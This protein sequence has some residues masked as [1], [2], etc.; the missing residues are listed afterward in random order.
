[1]V[2][3]CIVTASRVFFFMSSAEGPEVPAPLSKTARLSSAQ[4][5]V[6]SLTCTLFT[7]LSYVLRL[8]ISFVLGFLRLA[9]G[10]AVFGVP[11]GQG[12]GAP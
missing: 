10:A 12:W 1:M 11:Q 2:L 4:L 9:S 5:F 8:S 7:L 3:Y 6:S